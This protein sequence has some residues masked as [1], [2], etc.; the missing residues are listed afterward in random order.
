MEKLPGR[1]E[2]SLAHSDDLAAACAGDAADGA[3][4]IDVETRK[5]LSDDF[6]RG[7]FSPADRAII[8]PLDRGGTEW[9]LRAWCAKEALSKALGI[10]MRFDA[11]KLALARANAATGTVELRLTGGWAEA[12]PRHAAGPVN[13]WTFATDRFV[14]AL[15]SL[16]AAANPET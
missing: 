15:C 13:I 16:P 6:M 1:I 4:G 9:A 8:D 2:I 12:S 14:L 10:G 3:L 11:R 7:A 5:P